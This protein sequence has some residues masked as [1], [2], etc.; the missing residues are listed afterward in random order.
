MPDGPLVALDAASV[1][2]EPTGIG[3]YVRELAAALASVA[4]ARVGFIGVRPGGPMDAPRFRPC[5][6]LAGGRYVPWLERHAERDARSIGAELVHYTSA[7]APVSARLPYVVTVHDLSALHDPLHH[8]PLRVVRVLWMALGVHRARA[9]ITPSRAT[10]RDVERGL[11]VSAGRVV[12]VPHAPVRRLTPGMR[13]EDAEVLVRHGVTMG[14]YVFATGGLDS[15]KNPVRLVQALELLARKRPELRLVIAGPPGFRAST[16][17]AA[18]RSSS[19]A[20]RVR[21]VGYLSDA[22]L[23]A[24]LRNAAVFSFVSLHEGFGLPILEAMSAG[25]PVVTSRITSMPE[26]AGRAA[27]LVDPRDVGA[28][29]RGLDEALSRREELTRAGLARVQSRTWRDVAEETLDVYRWAATR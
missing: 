16:I 3:I 4:P 11:L 9:V 20:D 7:I 17:E 19:M 21:L 6:G 18:I 14:G 22:E 28:I 24:L 12:V 1:R 25:V 29:A 27:V 23:E 15:R 5:V 13:D 10:G 8:P 2:R 26:V